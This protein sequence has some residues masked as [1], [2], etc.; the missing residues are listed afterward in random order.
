M[1]N[2]IPLILILV[3]L[4][5]IIT[6]VLKKFS[7]LANLDIETIQTEREA[8]VKERIISKRLKRNFFRYFSK[9]SRGFKP[10]GT[11]ISN[12]FKWSYKKLI[13]FK[14]NY[15]KEKEIVSEDSEVVINKLFSEAE[16]LIK[17]DDLNSAEN[18]YIEIIGIDSKNIKAFKNLGKLYVDRKNYNEAKETLEHALRLL[19]KDYEE[20]SLD[21]EA[22]E[23]GQAEDINSQI[24]GICNSLSEI[25]RAAEDYGEAQKRIEK[26]L[27]IEPNNPRYLD[28]KLEI[29][30]IN[31]DKAAALDAYD[32]LKE[33]NPDNKK[34]D[35]FQAQIKEL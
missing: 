16:D 29:S 22:K 1:Y 21:G 13:E 7:V 28:T 27:K 33:V 25:F 10:I 34:L 24:A 18:K 8:K 32:K 4:G 12:F 3:S 19:E 15:N 30:I 31:K 23:E 26:A 35:D 14:D 5:I 2:I 17:D 11:G 6:I 20:A 9:L